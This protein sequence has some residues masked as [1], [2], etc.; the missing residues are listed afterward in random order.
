[1]NDGS[2]VALEQLLTDMCDAQTQL[3]QV[4]QR[5]QTAMVGLDRPTMEE[6]TA[7]EFRLATRLE[8]INARKGLWA[9]GLADAQNVRLTELAQ[10]IELAPD[11][12]RDRLQGLYGRLSELRDEVRR[13]NWITLSTGKQC[14][15]HFRSMIEILTH[16]TEAV[17]VYSPRG[18]LSRA[19]GGGSL[20]DDMA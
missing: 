2:A 15:E 16:G 8:D 6:C 11:S 1:M 9:Q 18:Q 19:S 7:E 10:A 13:L 12:Y 17:S 5:K 20:I 4:A 3:A 14:V